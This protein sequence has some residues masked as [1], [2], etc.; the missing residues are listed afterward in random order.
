LAG[1]I[2]G[3]AGVRF[4]AGRAHAGKQASW[5]VG[6]GLDTTARGFGDGKGGDVAGAETLISKTPLDCY[7]CVRVRAQISRIK[8][9]W[10]AA[11]RWFAEAA[12][13]GPS[14]PFAFSEWGDMR[15]AK[16][17]VEGA[18]ARYDEALEYAP[19]WK[20]LA[21]AREAAMKKN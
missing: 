14:L 1:G 20:A 17:D 12:R 11:E 19:K 15:L 21:K 2:G 6:A 9:D 8:R 10:P 3:C 5:P 7:L 4:V 16:G 18:I 13:Q